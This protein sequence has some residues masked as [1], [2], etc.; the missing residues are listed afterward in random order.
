MIAKVICVRKVC[1]H[2]T[3]TIVVGKIIWSTTQ[4]LK[5]KLFSFLLLLLQ[6]RPHLNRFISTSPSKRA[7]LL[8]FELNA[9]TRVYHRFYQNYSPFPQR[10]TL[11]DC[12]KTQSKHAQINTTQKQTT[13]KKGEKKR[14]KTAN[15]DF[16]HLFLLFLPF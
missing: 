2:T 7:T 9:S 8:N 14:K 4:A 10:E 12:S 6:V 13:K 3:R 11:L 5:I 1:A 15:L 16:L